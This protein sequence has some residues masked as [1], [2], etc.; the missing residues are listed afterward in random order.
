MFSGTQIVGF[1]VQSY[2]SHKARLCA[3]GVAMERLLEKAKLVFVPLLVALG[4]AGTLHFTARDQV[5]RAAACESCK[6]P[7]KQQIEELQG[8]LKL[9]ENYK[10]KNPKC[11]DSILRKVNSNITIIVLKIDTLKLK[12]DASCKD[13]S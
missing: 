4:L 11:G 6:S 5:S 1:V 10:L 9:N 8:K 7:L 12:L 3:I 2:T 13:C